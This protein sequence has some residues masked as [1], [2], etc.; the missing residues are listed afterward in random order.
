M[1]AF[2]LIKEYKDSPPLRTCIYQCIDKDWFY[3]TKTFPENWTLNI[4]AIE[5]H[6]DCWLEITDIHEEA[7]EENY[8][9]VTFNQSKLLFEKCNLTRQ[10]LGFTYSS[11]GRPYYNESGELNG[12][13]TKHIKK[14][15]NNESSVL[16]P[17]PEHHQ[18]VKFFRKKYGIWISVNPENYNATK[19]WHWT[20]Y[21]IDTEVN[22]ID[23]NYASEEKCY[24]DAIDYVLNNML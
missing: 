13:C 4:N 3:E 8:S 5:E 21:K 9:Y 18:V 14:L 24:E 16:Y 10:E 1:R 23:S 15:I 17:V 19:R 2:K 22:F 7:V 12:D 6:A 11:I 20:V